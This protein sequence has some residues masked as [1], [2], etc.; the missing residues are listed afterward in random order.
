MK[1]LKRISLVQFYLHEAVDIEVAGATAF[2][3]PNGSGKSSTLD[4]IQIAMLGGNQQYTRFNTQS[5][6]T[7]QRR[8]LA[9]YCLGMLR[10]PEKDSEVIGRARD[11]ARTY[12]ILVFG[13]NKETEWVSAGICIEADAETDEHEVKGLFVLPGLALK[14]DD[15]IV[16]DGDDQR[17][18]PFAD[19]RENVREQARNKGRTPIFTD[20]SSECVFRRR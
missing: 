3:G 7:K 16:Y 10:N 4:A 19:F 14:A 6:S 1:Q 2:L 8:S 5:V 11:E 20:K 13:D 12:I 18:I 15:C 17:P 9:G